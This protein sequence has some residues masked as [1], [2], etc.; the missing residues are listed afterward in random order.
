MVILYVVVCFAPG[1]FSCAVA[2][3][4]SSTDLAASSHSFA[5]S[6]MPA[7]S[8][9]SNDVLIESLPAASV[10][11]FDVMAQ[12]PPAPSTTSNQEAPPQPEA[13]A[14]SSVSSWQPIQTE[15]FADLAQASTDSEVIGSGFAEA[16][17]PLIDASLWRAGVDKGLAS[18]AQLRRSA[19]D[20][21]EDGLSSL[22][23]AAETGISMVI[24][25]GLVI[26]GLALLL[27]NSFQQKAEGAR[28]AP[29]AIVQGGAGPQRQSLSGTDA[30]QGATPLRATPDRGMAS[31]SPL[32]ASLQNSPCHLSSAPLRNSSPLA[33]IAQGPIAA[34]ASSPLPMLASPSSNQQ[35]A[36]LDT[37]HVQVGQ[38][39]VANVGQEQKVV[40]TMMLNESEKTV[41]V[42]ECAV[43]NRNGTP[44]FKVTQ[45]G[46]KVALA[47]L[48]QGPFAIT[49]GR[50]PSQVSML[51][52]KE[53]MPVADFR[54]MSA[55]RE[56]Q[57][58]GFEDSLEL[59]EVLTSYGGNVNEALREFWA[60]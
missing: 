35:A 34:Q 53:N 13:P 23:D 33:E 38:Y 20:A 59:R 28:G 48:L 21:L 17:T 15:N 39:Y 36:A 16:F 58:R 50:A 29:N 11:T 31:A 43:T 9:P 41:V 56:M 10:P 51:F 2:G 44:S 12:A 22:A 42:K 46:H 27:A 6:D 55:I 8:L 14:K 1:C 7:W 30:S 40:K 60:S 4:A 32:A 26:S 57:K 24:S 18:A 54:Y 5:D 45:T 37:R 19:S 3:G 49:A 25:G 52:T 47:A